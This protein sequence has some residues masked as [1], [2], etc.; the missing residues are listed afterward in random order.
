VKIIKS[1]DIFETLITRPFAPPNRLF[2][3]IAE[4]ANRT[5]GLSI[6]P[7]VFAHARILAE[8]GI[9]KKA[10]K[11]EVTIR[12]IYCECGVS[13]NLSED[14]IE[15]LISCEA[16][17]EIELCRPIGVGLDRLESA[18]RKCDGIIFISDMYLPGKV[19]QQILL[20]NGCWK[21]GDRL[22]VSCEVGATKRSGEM[23]RYV[24]ERESIS[25]DQLVHVGS[26]P[27]S[28]VQIPRRMGIGVEPFL[29]GNLNTRESNLAG[30]KDFGTL[31]P[32]LL[33]GCSRLARL[34]ADGDTEQHQRV[35][36]IAAHTAG[37]FLS[38]FVLWVLQIAKEVG[39]KRIY[40]ISRDGFVLLKV[41]RELAR[42]VYPEIELRYLYGSRQ[43][44]HF[45]ASRGIG[46]ENASWVWTWSTSYSIATVLSR[47]G[48]EP[49]R[50]ALQLEDAGISPAEW[51]EPMSRENEAKLKKVFKQREFQKVLIG[52]AEKQR[53]LL[54]AYLRQEG[55]FSEVE[56][57]IV[58]VG[59]KGKL[60]DS[61]GAILEEE[62]KR[63][64]LP[65]FYVGLNHRGIRQEKGER[66]TF[67]FDL[68]T[69]P[70]W[71]L[72]IAQ[73]QSCIEAF[74][75]A[76][77]GSV[78]GY[79]AEGDAI[80]PLLQSWKI[81]PFESW[82]LEVLHS[83]ATSYAKELAK[84]LSWLREVKIDPML[85]VYSLALTWSRPT[86]EEAECLGSF[87]FIEHQ[88][89][90]GAK[91]LAR[92]LPWRHFVRIM[93]TKYSKSYRVIWVEGC[94]R[95]TPEPRGSLLRAANLLKS[96]GIWALSWNTRG[97]P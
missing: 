94:L 70:R 88:S 93:K 31:I 63:S 79:C 82:G 56:S 50:V 4:A 9:R 47:V 95:L 49:H 36:E 17:L 1:F 77:H 32:G 27:S 78:V 84:A 65:G 62:G 2:P 30:A 6:D 33:A 34:S 53:A 72:K 58:D 7:C 21:D 25:A 15:A 74:C 57:A 8:K 39:L 26:D 61:L 16:Q 11:P 85:A 90:V 10:A 60:Q 80:A 73:P 81:E 89:G 43:A 67:L 86:L 52:E 24:L 22:Y 76:N 83:I 20:R 46:L 13:L 92:P 38:G 64:P 12:E 3:L 5:R 51:N 45:P 14:H 23:F 29:Q 97:L 40:F 55:L 68:R 44:W 91:P 37:P 87:P 96:A 48:V 19:L 75:S 66:R 69:N 59:W 54:V 18:R 42:S 35:Q 28:D 41:A 71:R